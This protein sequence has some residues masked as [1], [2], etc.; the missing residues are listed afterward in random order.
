MALDRLPHW[1][2]LCV[3]CKRPLKG[4]PYGTTTAL[5]P[6]PTCHA[7]LAGG[8]IRPAFKVVQ[9]VEQVPHVVEEE[10][11]L[12][13][14]PPGAHQGLLVP[15]RWVAVRPTGNGPLA[16]VPAEFEFESLHPRAVH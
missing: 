5:P 14:L 6:L 4:A 9:Q 11:P 12:G 1:I 13:S 8:H 10:W 15:P 7:D 2:L 3:D 16:V